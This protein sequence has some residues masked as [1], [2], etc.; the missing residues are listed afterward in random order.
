MQRKRY[1]L[2][3]HLSCKTR[4]HQINIPRHLIYAEI[5]I[6]YSSPPAS[7]EPLAK[8]H[9]QPDQPLSDHPRQPL[10]NLHSLQRGSHRSPGFGR[11]EGDGKHVPIALA[12]VYI[13]IFIL[14]LS[15]MIHQNNSSHCNIYIYIIY[16]L[17][18]IFRVP[19]FHLT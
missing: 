2:L 5:S 13:Y 17:R 7:P 10:R 18:E 3:L 11:S 4:G 6:E 8:F 9:L 16:C 15:Y 12:K 1:L 19:P 14:V